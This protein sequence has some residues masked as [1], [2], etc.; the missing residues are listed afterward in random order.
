MAL[1]YLLLHYASPSLSQAC[2]WLAEGKQAVLEA[3][4]AFSKQGSPEHE[5]QER[6][7]GIL[8][9]SEMAHSAPSCRAGHE[10]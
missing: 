1:P 7:V 9:R 6:R 2:K 10:S 8:Q 3:D 4:V 5:L